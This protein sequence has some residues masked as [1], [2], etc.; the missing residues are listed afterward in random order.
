[1]KCGKS[2]R[3]N[4]ESA[5]RL[6]YRRSRRVPEK[7]RG[8]WAVGLQF[9]LHEPLACC[10]RRQ[11]KAGV[12]IEAAEVRGIRSSPTYGVMLMTSGRLATTTL[13]VALAR[14]VR[15]TVSLLPTWMARWPPRD[16]FHSAMMNQ[17]ASST[18]ASEVHVTAL[19]A[20][21]QLR[22]PREVRSSIVA[23][24]RLRNGVATRW[25]WCACLSQTICMQSLRS[26]G[27][28]EFPSLGAR[29]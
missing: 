25:S 11:G 21:T 8:D 14:E 13:Q 3:A 5:A 18:L 29:V 2:D 6:A 22:C 19:C 17:A 9:A 12:A 20:S 4:A 27:S 1:M 7:G 16:A 24:L 10:P 15:E 23:K 28:V 26:L